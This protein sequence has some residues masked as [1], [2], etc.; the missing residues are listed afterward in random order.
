MRV[1]MRRDRLLRGSAQIWSAGTLAL[2]IFM[3]TNLRPSFYDA[4]LAIGGVLLVAWCGHTITKG[5]INWHF[6]YK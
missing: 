6:Q 1:N 2:V 5:A 4:A 3:L